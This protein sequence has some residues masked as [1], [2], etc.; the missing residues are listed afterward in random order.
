MVADRAV[1]TTSRR[2]RARFTEAERG[3]TGDELA[4]IAYRTGP[5]PVSLVPAPSTRTWIERTDE[6]FAR[7]CLPLMMACQAGWFLL[8]SHTF[9]ARWDGGDRVDALQLDFLSGVPP[10]PALSHFGYGVLTFHIPYL[11]RT[12]R[13]WNLLARGPANWPKDGV[14]PL[15]GLVETDWAMA[16]FTMNWKL[17]AVGRP[18]TFEAG[19]PFCM[20][21]P[22]RRGELERFRP[23]VTE[24]EAEPEVQRGYEAWGE[25]REQFLAGLEDGDP[26]VVRQAWQKDYFRGTAPDGTAAPDH[27]TKL[28]LWEVD[29]LEGWCAPVDRAFGS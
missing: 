26:E 12:P 10:Y 23:R 21:V 5:P 1:E 9:Q 29:D 6:R 20:V 14:F 25:S 11:F 22:Q 7:R 28:R 13:G 17:T 27:Q 18:V 24:I 2:G 16:T 19:E 8:N 3:E 4:L 15:E